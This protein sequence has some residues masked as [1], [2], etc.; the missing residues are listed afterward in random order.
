[1][2]AAV[3]EA[4]VLQTEAAMPVLVCC[5]VSSQGVFAMHSPEAVARVVEKSI[6]AS[7]PTNRRRVILAQAKAIFR[8]KIVVPAVRCFNGFSSYG[9]LPTVDLAALVPAVA[10][11]QDRADRMSM[12]ARIQ[13]RAIVPTVAMELQATRRITLTN[14][15]VTLRRNHSQRTSRQHQSLQNRHQ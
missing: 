2:D 12:P 8:V 5:T 4:A 11:I 7:K 9:V 6:T 3:V 1:M 15:Q 13:D 10:A 14:T